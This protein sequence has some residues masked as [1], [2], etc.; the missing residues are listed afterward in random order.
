MRRDGPVR[1][2]GRGSPVAVLAALLLAGA[3]AA[4][5]V[6]LASAATPDPRIPLADQIDAGARELDGLRRQIAERRGQ[7]DSLSTRER[8]ASR[9]LEEVAEEVALIR[10]LLA[11]L[12]ERE[13]MLQRQRDS[14]HVSLEEHR[15]RWESRQRDLARRMRSLHVRGPEQRWQRVFTAGSFSELMTQLRFQT[16]LA[17]M[18]GRLVDETRRQARLIESQERHLQA[19][20]TELWQSREEAGQ[21]RLRLDM[22]EAEH[23]ALLR[24]VREENRT[25]QTS[26]QRLEQRE[27][28]LR[29]VLAGLEERRV[30]GRSG[31][32]DAG[33]GDFAA[34]AGSL[35]WPARGEVVRAFGRS[36]HPDYRTVT[37]NN[38]VGIAAG[39]GAPVY[40]VAAG[41]VVF[42]DHLPGFGECVIVD[43]GAGY[44]SLYANLGRVYAARGTTVARGE[45]LAEVAAA[46]PHEET[47]ELYFEIRQG[48]T[49]LDPTGWLRARR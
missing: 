11:G 13:V 2:S 49:P 34:L 47:A 22:A 35:E 25:A 9:S 27:Q 16:I 37:M 23:Q 26:L 5:P 19:A 29:D 1:W 14:L 40:A 43:H 15:A 41:D 3:A 8:E 32:R 45:I 18:D 21:E 10:T 28:Q 46:L 17:R 39:A 7:V 38:G 4:G 20:L 36:V 42:A 44:Y 48:K 12:A 24:R 30:G 6:L 31:G 33:A